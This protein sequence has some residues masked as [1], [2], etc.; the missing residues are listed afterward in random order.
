MWIWYYKNR[1]YFFLTINDQFECLSS[2]VGQSRY[3]RIVE[4]N[5]ISFEPPTAITL[6]ILLGYRGIQQTIVNSTGVFFISLV[7]QYYI[8]VQYPF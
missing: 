1:V 5:P 4:P 7:T 6:Q 8:T 2:V 3:K